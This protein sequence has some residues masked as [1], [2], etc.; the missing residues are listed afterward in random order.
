MSRRLQLQVTALLL[1]L[2]VGAACLWSSRKHIVA[3]V[4]SVIGKAVDGLLGASKTMVGAIAKSVGVQAIAAAIS[5]A[6][7]D[8][9]AR[10]RAPQASELEHADNKLWLQVPMLNVNQIINAG[11]ELLGLL[12]TELGASK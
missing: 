6:V 3:A 10:A 11:L 8:A 12:P 7:A 2:M 9:A 5:G 4:Q 1:V